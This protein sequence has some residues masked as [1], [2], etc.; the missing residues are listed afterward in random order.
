VNWRARA[1]RLRALPLPVVLA[2]LEAIRSRTQHVSL[3]ED[4][5]FMGIYVEEMG[6]PAGAPA[7]DA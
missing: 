1:D 4:S 6:F 2:A 3:N 5:R 7:N